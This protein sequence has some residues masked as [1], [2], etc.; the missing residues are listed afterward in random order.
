M[1][2]IIWQSWK[3]GEEMNCSCSTNLRKNASSNLVGYKKKI[4]TLFNLSR[5]DSPITM[6]PM[7]TG[8]EI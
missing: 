2:L 7:E 1:R 4:D 6:R 8:L 3:Q 5:D